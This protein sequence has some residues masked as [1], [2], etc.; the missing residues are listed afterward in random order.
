MLGEF[1]R[2]FNS[3]VQKLMEK[4]EYSRKCGGEIE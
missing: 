2:G 4:K 3:I 1:D